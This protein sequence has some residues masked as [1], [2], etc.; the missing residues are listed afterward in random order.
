MSVLSGSLTAE[1]IKPL[2]RSGT[3]M[4]AKHAE[5][6][7]HSY[8]H[9]NLLLI[10]SLNLKYNFM[11]APGS[12]VEQIVK[13]F[14]NQQTLKNKFQ[15]I[16]VP[17]YSHRPELK[18]K[19][20]ES[21]LNNDLRYILR[22]GQIEHLS[23]ENLEKFIK[24]AICIKLGQI[25][26]LKKIGYSLTKEQITNSMTTGEEKVIE[27]FNE[28]KKFG[29][30]NVDNF[31]H[32]YKDLKI[33][34]NKIKSIEGL[35]F[36]DLKVRKELNGNPEDRFVLQ[37]ISEEIEEKTQAISKASLGKRKENRNSSE[38]EK[39]TEY[40]T[41]LN[42]SL[43]YLRYNAS[44]DARLS[45][46]L[47]AAFKFIAESRDKA[48]NAPVIKHFLA[49][50][51]ARRSIFWFNRTKRTPKNP[52][53]FGE[54]KQSL[55]KYEKNIPDTKLLSE[56]GA[57]WFSKKGGGMENFANHPTEALVTAIES[58][59]KIP[60]NIRSAQENRNVNI[61]IIINDKKTAKISLSN[62]ATKEEII[63]AIKM[64]TY[65]DHHLNADKKYRLKSESYKATNRSQEYTEFYSHFE[66]KK[67]A[68]KNISVISNVLGKKVDGDYIFRL[69]TKETSKTQEI[70]SPFS[71][72]SV[73]SH[74]TIVDI[75][76]SGGGTEAT[77]SMKHG[78][79]FTDACKQK[80]YFLEFF[81]AFKSKSGDIFNEENMTT[82]SEIDEAEITD[83]HSE[84]IT[85]GHYPLLE[86]TAFSKDL[87]FKT[88]IIEKDKIALG[89]SIIGPIVRALTW[90][91]RDFYCLRKG[92]EN[93]ETEGTPYDNIQPVLITTNPIINVYNEFKK[94]PE[95]FEFDSVKI[96]I[97]GTWIDEITQAIKRS[98][99]GGSDHATVAAPTGRLEELIYKGT[100]HIDDTPK[101]LKESKMMESDLIDLETKE[102]LDNI[103][104]TTA[105]SDSNGS[106]VN[107]F[108]STLINGGA[109]GVTYS[110]T[111]SE[112][113][114]IISCRMSPRNIQGPL[115]SFIS[116]Q[117][118][119]LFYGDKDFVKKHQLA[120]VKFNSLLASWEDL[121]VGKISFSD[122]QK[123]L[124]DVYK[125]LCKDKICG[126]NNLRK[127]Q[128]NSAKELQT[129]LNYILRRTAHDVIDVHKKTYDPATQMPST[130]KI[131][132]EKELF[133]L[134]MAK[135]RGAWIKNI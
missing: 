5:I 92:P 34:L 96:N 81:K 87:G 106:P 90:G 121:T 64:T 60:I 57:W 88:I 31:Y 77:I 70:N 135:Y 101:L 69:T 22:F 55:K 41:H 2:G 54:T 75:D 114:G 85:N 117:E 103:S 11:T 53:N 98:D 107:L 20:Y 112:G 127:S 13:D 89:A 130:N 63:E 49:S 129:K 10:K 23:K 45:D 108:D 115:R 16:S 47:V 118:G 110:R 65:V 105:E 36:L 40:K 79:H 128:I 99:D 43:E 17:P 80:K 32:K 50:C 84:I 7:H 30:L 1:R 113:L 44:Q 68:G 58:F 19:Y 3:G 46:A 122:Y 102:E 33:R 26:E 48:A 14:I 12:L 9:A 119:Q 124:N 95:E 42:R 104:F 28:I 76:F 61:M 52:E 91:I 35:F 132:A 82:Y 83:W 109:I 120:L 18:S 66:P 123:K 116:N 67:I 133:Y 72:F 37:I 71:L 97:V 39:I 38:D 21:I 93:S 8:S 74:K 126:K 78:H 125:N 94:A 86:A 51:M 100:K 134:F 29:L 73:N 131:V 111:A 15:N 56:A 27:I 25:S 6:L 24:D 59:L 62:N 4:T